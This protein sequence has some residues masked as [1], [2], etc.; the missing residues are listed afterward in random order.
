MAQSSCTCNPSIQVA[1][2]GLELQAGQPG[3]H[4]AGFASNREGGERKKGGEE[5]NV[6]VN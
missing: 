4:G 1:V 3:L 5:R 2:A 6:E